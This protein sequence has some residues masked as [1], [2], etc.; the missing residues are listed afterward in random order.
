[1]KA[2][3][4]YSLLDSEEYVVTQ[5]AKKL[6]EQ[7]FYSDTGPYKSNDKID[8]ETF[9]KI[10]SS[11]LFIGILMHKTSKITALNS[12]NQR[13]INEWEFTNSLNIPA[14]LLV[15][16]S[17]K[18]D[19]PLNNN[20]NILVFD[21][22][23]P[24][25]AIELANKTIEE[26]RRPLKSDKTNAAAWILGGLAIVALIVFLAKTTQKEKVFTT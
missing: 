19:I 18:L 23:H 26:S 5:L 13:V 16:K 8:D 7:G 21:K 17:V 2:F 14:V 24:E 15:E 10:K 25:K 20:A 12:L 1:M 9:F 3:I 11:H 6:R 22:Q 4:S